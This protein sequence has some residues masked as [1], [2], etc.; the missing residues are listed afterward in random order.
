[1]SSNR[2]KSLFD[3]EKRPVDPLKTLF[4]GEPFDPIEWLFGRN[5]SVMRSSHALEVSELED[6]YEVS[7][8]VPGF[9]KEDLSVTVNNGLLTVSGKIE[10]T[11]GNRRSRSEFVRRVSLGDYCDAEN[12]T[13]T[14]KDGVL[15]ISIPKKAGSEPKKI[16]I[17]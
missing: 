8:D 12:V 4:T 13:A 1:M 2:I 7:L 10:N 6:R 9:T 17:E 15:T 14:S 5:S 3:V 11:E 16:D